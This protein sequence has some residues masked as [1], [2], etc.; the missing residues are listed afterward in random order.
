MVTFSVFKVYEMLIDEQV[1][2][3]VLSVHYN[4]FWGRGLF[5]F[6]RA[7]GGSQAEGPMGAIAASLG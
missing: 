2:W 5:V 1:L 4:F 3:R 6:S 7:C